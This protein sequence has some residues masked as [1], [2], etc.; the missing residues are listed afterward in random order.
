M[1]SARSEDL[2]CGADCCQA[3]CRRIEFE[4]DLFVG[5]VVI[6]V[7]GIPSAPA[8]LFKGQRR[9]TSIAVQV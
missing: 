1:G 9:R 6:W 3:G 4:T 5:C 2:C 8:G 7:G